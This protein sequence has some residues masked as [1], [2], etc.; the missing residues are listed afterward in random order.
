ML[1]RKNESCLSPHQDGSICSGEVSFVVE[2]DGRG[3]DVEQV[4]SREATEMGMG[5]V[6]MEERARMVGGSLDIWSQKGT[7]TRITFSI[8]MN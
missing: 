3:F 2:D 7:G 4:F 5:L 6:T 1:I 8:P